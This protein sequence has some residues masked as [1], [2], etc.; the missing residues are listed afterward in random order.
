MNCLPEALKDRRFYEPREA[1]AEAEMK[2]R[3]ERMRKARKG[4][5]RNSK[6]LPEHPQRSHRVR[7][8]KQRQ[9]DK[10]RCAKTNC[11]Q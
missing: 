6:T 1:G 8:H 3:L 2:V 5:G 10:R 4:E 11:D 7:R 9:H